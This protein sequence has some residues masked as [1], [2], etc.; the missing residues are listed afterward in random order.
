MGSSR[1]GQIPNFYQKFVLKASLALS[2][3]MMMTWMKMVMI[4]QALVI[5]TPFQKVWTI[6]S[7]ECE[8]LKS[9]R[10]ALYQP[11]HS[12]TQASLDSNDFS[13]KE[14]IEILFRIIIMLILI[15]CDGDGDGHHNKD[16]LGVMIGWE[17]SDSMLSPSSIT[18]RHCNKENI[19]WRK[20]ARCKLGDIIHPILVFDQIF[21][22][23]L[24]F[25]NQFLW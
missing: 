24:T 2:Y 11:T 3:I 15:G 25:D 4:F 23:I 6:M 5:S 7:V 20:C 19:P 21:L 10:A 16:L 18:S 8:K 13:S 12:P 9:K 1:L 22:K 14:N 17:F